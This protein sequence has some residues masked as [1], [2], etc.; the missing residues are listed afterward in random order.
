MFNAY[1]IIVNCDKSDMLLVKILNKKV[2]IHYDSL[3]KF[4][5]HVEWLRKEMEKYCV[6]YNI[7]PQ[8]I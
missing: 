3:S 4:K 2:V 7:I 8:F 5:Y 6:Y 1:V